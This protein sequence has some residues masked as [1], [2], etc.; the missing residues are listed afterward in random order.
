MRREED[1]KD[2]HSKMYFQEWCLGKLNLPYV[3]MCKML[4]VKKSREFIPRLG[5]DIDI[6]ATSYVKNARIIFNHLFKIFNEGGDLTTEPQPCILAIKG[7]DH[8]VL[9]PNMHFF[10]I[11]V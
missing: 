4:K 10:W 2:A 9:T 1:R 7:E 5:D 11:M 3:K 8:L 6:K